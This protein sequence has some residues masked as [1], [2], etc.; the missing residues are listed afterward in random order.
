MT[1]PPRSTLVSLHY[2][3]LFKPY[4]IS[5]A[6]IQLC[7]SQMGCN[8]HTYNQKTQWLF[9]QKRIQSQFFWF[10]MLIFLL[11]DSQSLCFEYL[12]KA[13][14][15]I[16]PF[17]LGDMGIRRERKQKLLV[18]IYI[19]YKHINI[20]MRKKLWPSSFTQWSHDHCWHTAFLSS[21]THSLYPKQ[22][23]QLLM[24]PFLVGGLKYSFL[25][26]LGY[27]WSCLNWVVVV[28]L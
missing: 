27:L 19:I 5:Q 15:Y 6:M 22:A 14:Y 11:T 28:F 17:G 12:Y 18:N 10:L 7:F 4:F 21:A 2:T 25:K 13:S 3:R 16:K 23:L 20:K 1:K 26:G 9:P 24:V 8:H